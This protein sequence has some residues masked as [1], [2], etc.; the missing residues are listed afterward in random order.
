M[1]ETGKCIAAQFSLRLDK[2]GLCNLL[3]FGNKKGVELL[4]GG[5]GLHLRNKEQRLLKCK[6]TA[7]C[8]IFFKDAL[9]TDAGFSPSRPESHK[10]AFGCAWA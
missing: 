9:H 3:V 1:K 6:C 7:P 10:T 5:V 4:S 2:S 8:K